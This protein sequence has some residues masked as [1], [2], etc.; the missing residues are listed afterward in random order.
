M[1]ICRDCKFDNVSMKCCNDNCKDEDC[2]LKKIQ[3]KETLDKFLKPLKVKLDFDEIFEENYA[4]HRMNSLEMQ[5]K[6][7]ER[8]QKL[9]DTDLHGTIEFHN[10]DSL[11]RKEFHDR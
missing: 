2:T 8:E 4:L 9:I 6:I 3:S 1:D 5:E 7:K 11:R 10:Y